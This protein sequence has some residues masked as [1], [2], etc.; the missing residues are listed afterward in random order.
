MFVKLNKSIII[1]LLLLFLLIIIPISFAEDNDSAVLNQANETLVVSIPFEENT[2]TASNDYYFDASAENDGDGS[3][4]N[5]YKYLKADRIRANANLYLANGEYQLDNPK[6]IEEVNIIGS[7]VESTIIKYDGVAFTVNNHLT[8]KNITFIGSSIN[9]AGKLDVCNSVFEQGH[10]SKPDNYLNNFG[11]AICTDMKDSIKPYVNVDNCTF[12]SNYA[13]Y[14]GA[15]Y[16]GNGNLNVSNSLF[17]DNV[18]YNYGGA[19]ACDYA[20]NVSISKSKF[21][22]SQSLD[23]AG[24]SIYI[25]QSS[26]LNADDISVSKSSSIFGGAITTLN[27]PVTLN[28]VN[29]A[30]NSAK[31]DGGAIYHMYGNFTLTYSIFNNNSANNGGAVFIDNS[32]NTVFARNTFTN[33]RA[34]NTGGAIYSLLNNLNAPFKRFNTF[35][36][37]MAAYENDYYDASNINLSI[38]DG[39]YTMYNVE[40]NPITSLPSRYSLIDDGYVTPVKDQ[41]TSGNCWAFTAIAVLE[42]CILK[43]GGEKLDLSEENMKNIIELYSDYGWKMDTNE[44][45]YDYMP[46]GYLAS[47]LGPVSEMDDLFDDKSTLSPMLKSIMHVQNIKFL[48]RNSYTDNDEIKKAILNY[49]AVGTGMYYYSSY[50]NNNNAYYCWYS[51]YGNHAVTIVG[52]DDNFSRD[53]FRYGGTIAGDGAWIVRNSWGPNWGNDGYFYVSYYDADFARPGVEASAYTIVLNDTIRFDKNY[54]YDIAGITDYLYNASSKVWYKNKFISSSDEYLA[55]VSTY[56]DK[57]SNWMATVIVNDKIMDV[58]SGWSSA[59]YYTFNLNKFIS[60]EKGDVIEVIF[61][62]TTAGEAG[63]PISEVYNLNKL[64]FAPEISYVSWDGENWSDL[65]NLSF[66]YGTHNYHPAVASI[67][68]FTYSNPIITLTNLSIDFKWDEL[69]NISAAVVDEYGNIVKYGNVTF[70][71]NGDNQNV[72][73][74]N[75]KASILYNITEKYNAISARFE[76]EGYNSSS[77]S[78]SYR[79][80]KIPIAWTL[81]ITQLFND[82]NITVVASKLINESIIMNIHGEN[83]PFAL[84][85]GTNTL[86]LHKLPNDLYAVY[87]SL[88]DDSDYSADILS[89]EF[90]VEV[91]GSKIVSDS[92]TANDD[93]LFSY[94]ITLLDENANPIANK[95]IVFSINNETYSNVTDDAGRAIIF[96]HLDKGIYEVNSSFKGDKNY[97]PSNA[98]NTIKIKGKIWI[99]LDISTYNNNAFISVY[100]S[101]PINETFMVMVN[102]K[103]YNVGSKDGLASLKLYNLPNNIYNVSVSL[104]ENEYEFNEAKSQFTIDFADN[105]EIQSDVEM[106][107]DDVIINVGIENASGYVN[108]IVDGDSKFVELVEGKANCSVENIAPGNHSLV[109]I[110]N[111]NFKS[112]QF[113]IPKKQSDIELTLNSSK[114][115]QK[116]TIAVNVTPKATGLV[117]IDINGTSYIVNLSQCYS[118][119]LVFNEAGSYRV[120]AT[121]LGDDN[122]ASSTSKEYVLAVEDKKITNIDIDVP[123]SIKVDENVEF[124]ISGDFGEG[125]KVYIDGELQRI[126]NNKINFKATKA[127]LH[128]IE[129]YSA[130]NEDYYEFNKTVPFNVVKNNA[131]IFIDIA[132]TVFVGQTIMINPVTDSDASLTVKVNGKVIDCEYVIPF[133]GTFVVTAECGETDRYYKAFNSTT[134]TAIK[135]SSMIS[136][137]AEAGKA[138]EKSIIAVN[139]SKGATGLVI[140]NVNGTQYSL[141]LSKTSILEVVLPKSGKYDVSA[142]YIGDD[143]YDAGQS[144]VKTIVVSEKQPANINVEI[145]DDVKVG[146]RISIKISADS[147]AELTITINGEVQYIIPAN[148]PLGS[149]LMNILKSEIGKV[150]YYVDHAGIYNIT[151]TARENEDYLCETFTKVFEASKKDAVIDIVPISDAK[152]GDVIS[153]IVVNETDGDLTIKVNGEKVRSDYEIIDAGSYTITVESAPTDAYN[154]GFAAYSFNVAEAEKQIS[155]VTI[156][157]PENIK[158]GESVNVEI[159]VSASSGNVSVIVDG[160]ET[161]AVLVNGSAGVLLDNVSAGT[162]NVVAIYPGDETHSPAYG[163]SS[164]NV[165]GNPAAVLIAS[166]FSDITIN[167]DLSI[168]MTLK[169]ETGKAISNAQIKYLVNGIAKTTLSDASGKFVIQAETGSKIAIEYAGNGNITGTNMTLKLSSPVVKLATRFNIDNDVSV[170]S[171]TIKGYAVDTLAGEEGMTYTTVLQDENGKAL[172]NV[173][174]SFAVNNKIYNRTTY[175]NGSFDPYH[176][177][178]IRAGRYTMAF[179]YGGDE[180]H[181]ATLACVC[182]DLDKKPITIKAS[183]KTFKASAKTKKYTVTLSTIAGSSLDGKTYLSAGKT[184]TLTIKD[185][186]FKAK[187]N[188]KGQ[189]TFKITS[190][191]KKGKYSATVF[192]KGDKTYEEATKNIKITIK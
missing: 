177:N 2:L 182:V 145:P 30:N 102:N 173:P 144:D 11:G 106:S 100:A 162:H 169:D 111:N 138:G 103:P 164:F 104:D 129:L 118:L 7:D 166:Q 49:G 39:N 141:D 51:T 190:L 105:V 25:R 142:T 115:G 183:A 171:I 128:A 61:N 153:I 6:S 188:S 155:N 159:I 92:L 47:W 139:I 62:I 119:D 9:N 58:L 185:K 140:V 135:H 37:N 137:D 27:T 80:P 93:G 52:W 97:F 79:I 69:S 73:V 101:N 83:I 8:I 1:T 43:A 33:N 158:S 167:D 40:V 168:S 85:N 44:G 131:N 160:K 187:T 19:I 134:F 117:S 31:Y 17:F 48:K 176:L 88:S 110:Y 109:I 66:E 150:E 35:I 132:K 86:T 125:L 5:P 53:N 55:A 98:S 64:V 50:M 10:G 82:V 74:E 18:A 22:N 133:K 180:R 156:M 87:V 65:Y 56:F 89:D 4:S 76:A 46:W 94:N 184:V 63:C 113:S 112:E 29:M 172:A 130:E 123:E 122:F 181:N 165:S 114:I 151:V 15:I 136:I 149:S 3:L 14:G 77:N 42:S 179:Y 54:Q 36:S 126:S 148:A 84:V 127:G 12:K 120:R 170:N 108:V 67:K 24:G 96:M 41:Q 152:V 32:T 146:D 174:I 161:V 143:K 13:I 154:A 116:S 38:G 68:A 189:A 57:A 107:G 72:N 91:Y 90:A 16:I 28:Q 124:N 26:S 121:Y 23:D 60:L 78:T 70:S 21:Y 175:A 81:N 59:G 191:N 71:I 34:N 186:T 99:N 45:G 20:G 95:E 178:M 157:V 75:G 147:D 163:T 192:F